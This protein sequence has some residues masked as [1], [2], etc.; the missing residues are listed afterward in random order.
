MF[1]LLIR[2]GEI[3]DGSRARRYRGDVAIQ[4]ERIVS[5]G[6]LSA[7]EANVTLNATAEDRCPRLCRC[8]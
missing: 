6:D 1:D 2:G 5:I 7:A 8:P 3:I 4:G